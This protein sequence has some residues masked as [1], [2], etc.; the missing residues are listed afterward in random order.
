MIAT[1]DTKGFRNITG[2]L[3]VTGREA[4]FF[5]RKWGRPVVRQIGPLVAIEVAEGLL[6]DEL[7]LS[8]KGEPR[9][10]FDLLAGQLESARD[11]VRRRSPSSPGA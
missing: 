6:M 5:C 1:A 7:V 4:I 3:C 10:R 11:E 9:Q 2:T 8:A